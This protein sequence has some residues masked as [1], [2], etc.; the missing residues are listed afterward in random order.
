MVVEIKNHH[1]MTQILGQKFLV[2][3]QGTLKN[4]DLVFKFIHDKSKDQEYFLEI[5]TPKGQQVR[6]IAVSD[7]EEIEPLQGTRFVI[8]YV[9][10]PMGS[11]LPLVGQIAMRA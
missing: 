9:T 7:I 2:Q 4:D 1:L 8:S 11:T 5:S 6:L 3:K 10:S